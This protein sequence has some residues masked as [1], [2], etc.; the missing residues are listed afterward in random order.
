MDK[1]VWQQAQA[2]VRTSGIDSQPVKAIISKASSKVAERAMESLLP[3]AA[4]RPEAVQEIVKVAV[5]QNPTYE[6]LTREKPESIRRAVIAAIRVRTAAKQENKVITDTDIHDFV[7]ALP[8]KTQDVDVKEDLR[9]SFAIIQALMNG[10]G[11]K[12][13]F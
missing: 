2:K 5:S 1:L 3:E 6:W 8:D 11:G 9:K 7:Y 10:R 12:L 13:P 4:L